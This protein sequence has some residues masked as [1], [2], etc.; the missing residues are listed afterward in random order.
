MQLGYSLALLAGLSLWFPAFSL[1]TVGNGTDLNVAL[2]VFA[3]LFVVLSLSGRGIPRASVLI[4]IGGWI[5]ILLLATLFATD[6]IASLKTFVMYL[7]ALFVLYLASILPESYRGFLLNGFFIGAIIS[8]AY[9]S[10]QLLALQHGWPGI[11]LLNNTEHSTYANKQFGQG[12]QR[13]W[14]FTHEP[15]E[16]AGLLLIAGCLGVAKFLQSS[17]KRFLFFTAAMVWGLFAS[18]SLSTYIMLPF[19]ALLLL[20]FPSWRH[21][22][23]V[24]SSIIVVSLLAIIVLVSTSSS[25]QTMQRLFSIAEDDSTLVRWGSM[26]G[27]LKM[28]ADKP[29]TGF[30]LGSNTGYILLTDYLPSYAALREAKMNIDS[31]PIS[32]MAYAGIGGIVLYLWTF[33]IGYKASRRDLISSA[34]LTTV[35]VGSAMH[36]L[37]LSYYIWAFLGIAIGSP[38]P[39]NLHIPNRISE[40]REEQECNIN[41]SQ[42]YILRS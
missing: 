42:K 26:V 22:I 23:T 1:I 7:S 9:E 25:N 34:S 30:G 21:Y 3:L 24:K 36:G 31:L 5:V 17:K 27:G 19:A 28:F 35:F 14:A 33:F 20:S 2:I 10:Y 38:H 16:L 4:I 40:D 11:S 29:V 8:V 37:F 13:A 39:N 6:Q 15:S 12:F 18:S 41:I 32:L